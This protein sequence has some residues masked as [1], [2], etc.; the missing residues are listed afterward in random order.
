MLGVIVVPRQPHHALKIQQTL[1]RALWVEIGYQN[2]GEVLKQ[3]FKNGP[4]SRFVVDV[5]N[6]SHVC[7]YPDEPGTIS[8]ADPSF[9]N[10]E[11]AAAGKPFDQCVV[12][13]LV[14]LGGFLLD[15]KLFVVPRATGSPKSFF[16]LRSTASWDSLRSMF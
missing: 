5:D 9:V 2:T 14:L 12:G 15:L 6:L 7:K 10:V 16:M 1:S 3:C 11:E 13:N 4:F 8:D